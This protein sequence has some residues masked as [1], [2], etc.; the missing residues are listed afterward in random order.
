MRDGQVIHSLRFSRTTV[1]VCA[2]FALCL[3][4]FVRNFWV[5]DDAYIIFRVVDNVLH[6]Y[7][8][9][10]NIAE[11]VQ[12]YICPLWTGLLTGF[13]PFVRDPYL[14]ALFLSAL[15]WLGAL[16]VVFSAGR[17]L[18]MWTSAGALLA[19]SSRS[20]V[21]YSSSGLENP[22]TMLI[23]GAGTLLFLRPPPGTPRHPLLIFT[24]AAVLFLTRI[25]A[26][27]LLAGPV[28]GIAAQLLMQRRTRELF[29][30][31]AGLIPA[32]L[33]LVFA[34][35]YFGSP[36]PNVYFA[37]LGSLESA[38]TLIK[39]GRLYLWATAQ[40][41]P[42]GAVVI[43]LGVVSGLF[44]L[45][46]RGAILVSLSILLYLFYVVWIGGDF[47]LGRF[48]AAPIAVSLVLIGFTVIERRRWR[49]YLVEAAGIA[50]VFFVVI[51][52]HAPLRISSN[53]QNRW[54][55]ER[56]YADEK[57]HYFP[58]T[59]LHV[60]MRGH[61]DFPDSL[62]TRQGK[63]LRAKNETIAVGRNMGFLGYHAGPHVHIID[64]HALTDP[65]LARL[66]GFK[67]RPGHIAR[68]VP[69]EYLKTLRTNESAFSNP[70]MSSLWADV[71]SAARDPLFS[72]ARPGAVIRLI[73]RHTK[74][75]SV[76]YKLRAEDLR[77]FRTESWWP[78]AART[79]TDGELSEFV[80][81]GR[82][83]ESR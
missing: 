25:D 68:F 71:K 3:Y 51:S 55:T 80:L 77:K 21:D 22:L 39:S 43:L 81:S 53:Y 13:T 47:M 30:A 69:D 4:A 10:W 16:F 28:L 14:S 58:E 64:E 44:V 79:M 78:A 9:R 31:C 7:G 66:R 11:R 45:R 17:F 36:L 35:F 67:E 52:P 6:G 57:G 73:I 63:E 42:V 74:P 8:I 34:S 62:W 27:L 18:P 29:A 19:V 60:Y 2:A 59:G 76:I 15:S 82:I 12:P 48:F 61:A 1:V 38:G 50:A 70:E 5:S 23:A 40:Y 72:R 46:T 24:F 37:K 65:F 20:F 83:F 56:G 32:G 33:W 41:D 75:M 26:V 49:L 54:M